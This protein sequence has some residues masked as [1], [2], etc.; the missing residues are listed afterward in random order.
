MRVIQVQF[1]A[2]VQTELGLESDAL[3]IMIEGSPSVLV[4]LAHEISNSILSG[5]GA[6]HFS[7]LR[8]ISPMERGLGTKR[9]DAWQLVAHA[10]IKP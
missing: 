1:P 2:Q 8:F 7:A 9:D 6:W 5:I 4:D 10:V 3:V